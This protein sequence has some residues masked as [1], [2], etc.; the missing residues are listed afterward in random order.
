MCSCL[1]HSLYSGKGKYLGTRTTVDDEFRSGILE[2]NNT[3]ADLT[4]GA[5]RQRAAK[6]D[7]TIEPDVSK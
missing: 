5:F 4:Q 3:E 1:S 2:V 7:Y 6:F